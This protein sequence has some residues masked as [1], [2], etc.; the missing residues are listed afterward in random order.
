MYC[1]AWVVLGFGGLGIPVPGVQA[2]AT[3][4]AG[5]GYVVGFAPWVGLGGV[6]PSSIAAYVVAVASG[7]ATVCV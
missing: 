4:L 5:V 3:V 2:R 7:S 6:D 1:F